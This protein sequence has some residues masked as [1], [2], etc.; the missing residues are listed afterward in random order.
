MAESAVRWQVL[1]VLAAVALGGAFL[2]AGG[3][4]SRA[5][6]EQRAESPEDGVV[7]DGFHYNRL[8]GRG[9]NLGNALEARREGSWGVFLRAEY[10]QLIRKAGFDSIRLPVRWSSR[11]GERFPYAIDESFFERV[12]WAIDQALEQGLVVIVNVHHYEELM[13][14]PGSHKERFLALWR[15]IAERYHD[16]PDRL[17]FEILNEPHNHLSAGLWNVYLKEALGVIRSS[18]PRR[19]VVV[20]SAHWNQISRLDALELPADDRNLIA[21]FHYY[22][23]FEFTHQG[24]D[25]LVESWPWLG[26]TWEGTPAEREAV[27]ADLERAA[28]W[29]RRENRPLTLG[30]FGAYRR[31]GLADRARWTA[32]VRQTAEERGISWSYWEFGAGFGLYDID[33]GRWK[34]DLLAAL[35]PQGRHSAR[36]PRSPSRVN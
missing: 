14:D 17:Y 13:N 34:Q 16:R 25:W 1:R 19:A 32:F 28:E 26:T 12:D 4:A 10:F 36:A 8:I 22:E 7:R 18:N 35:L 33:A 2:A 9:I 15:Q 3:P 31:A 21:A 5:S 24:A 20:G 6:D 23:P 27:V 30:E 11:A 29:G